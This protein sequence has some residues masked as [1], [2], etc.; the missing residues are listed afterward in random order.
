LRVA[1]GKVTSMRKI[2]VL[3]ATLVVFGALTASAF[4]Q[5]PRTI[6]YNGNGDDLGGGG[7]AGEVSSPGLDS[8]VSDSL[9]FTGF[10]AGLA[11][12]AGAGIAAAGFGLRRLGRNS[13]K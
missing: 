5:T 6:Q 13:S 4:A 1:N 12:A 9:P 8:G 10:Q 7:T 3:L 2:T 11:L